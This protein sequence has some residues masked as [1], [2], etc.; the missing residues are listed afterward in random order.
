[1]IIMGMNTRK[2]L[3]IDKKKYQKL[4]DVTV[5]EIYLHVHGK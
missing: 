2:Y 3:K 5:F 1:M 4:K